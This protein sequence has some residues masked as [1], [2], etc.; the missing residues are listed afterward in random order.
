MNNSQ[1]S[2]NS[3]SLNSSQS[4]QHITPLPTGEGPG[5]GLS[6][7]APSLWASDCRAARQLLQ[8][9]LSQPLPHCNSQRSASPHRAYRTLRGSKMPHV[10][11]P[12][13]R[14]W[15]V[16]PP[17]LERNSVGLRR[18]SVLCVLRRRHTS[19]LR[20]Q[21]GVSRRLQYGDNP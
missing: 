20:A 11:H 12:Y 18:E 1:V 7:E 10:R 15:R 9:D 17:A 16:A 5:V 6:G 4:A 13:K 8:A 2:N 14:P 19:V 3:Q 21:V